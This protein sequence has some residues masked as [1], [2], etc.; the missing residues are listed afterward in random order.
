MDLSSKN[1][2][3]IKEVVMRHSN[4]WQKLGDFR[5]PRAPVSKLGFDKVKIITVDTN[6]LVLAL[7][8]QPKL[9]ISMFVE[10]G[11]ASTVTIFDFSSSTFDDQIAAVLPSLYALSGCDSTSSF[12]G[13]GKSKALKNLKSD[14]PFVEAANLIGEEYLSATAIDVIE[15]Y[16]CRLYGE[17]KECST[18]ESCFNMVTGSITTNKRRTDVTL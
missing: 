12:N 3:K 2:I 5:C 17:K 1:K 11:T 16:V 14:G 8:H 15:E 18:I 10:M 4:F 6:V 9:E 7:Y 13:T